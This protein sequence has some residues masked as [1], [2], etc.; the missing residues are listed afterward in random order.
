M[1]GTQS[2]Q[3]V[4]QTMITEVNPKSFLLLLQRESCVYFQIIMPYFSYSYLQWAYPSTLFLSFHFPSDSLSESLSYILF[5]TFHSLFPSVILFIL[6]IFLYCLPFEA[7]HSL[8]SFM[9]LAIAIDKVINK[10]H[11]QNLSR[12]FPQLQE[13]EA[14]TYKNGITSAWRLNFRTFKLLTRSIRKDFLKCHYIK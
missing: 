1:E 3:F 8:L 7:L 9:S 4:I 14:L 6:S 5:F 10:I 11:N 12:A 13:H 2:S